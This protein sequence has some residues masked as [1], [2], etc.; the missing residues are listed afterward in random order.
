MLRQFFE[1]APGE[2]AADAREKIVARIG[3]VDS[4]LDAWIPYLWRLLGVCGDGL[5]DKSGEEVKR[6]T[7][8][9]VCRLTGA[10]DARTPALLVV[11]DLH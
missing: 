4:S 11:E 3:A 5:D 8:E 2:P 6:G 10:A 7:I 1:I 9:A